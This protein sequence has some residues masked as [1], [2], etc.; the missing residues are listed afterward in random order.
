MELDLNSLSAMH[1]RLGLSTALEYGYRVAIGLGRNGHSPAV[2]LAVSLDGHRQQGHLNWLAAPDGA[3]AQL[4][5]HR[6]T[7]DTAEAVALALVHVSKGWVV[8]RRLQ[9]REFGDWRL[10]DADGNHI[11][12]EV[13]G[14]DKVDTG[15]RRLKEKL[16]Q[17]ER[18]RT[19]GAKVACV[20][21]LAPPRSRLKTAWS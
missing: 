9:R 21:E 13:S 17:V 2:N 5:F 16:K 3:D 1:P 18:C 12:L 15:Q 11:A 6:I 14:V 4:D 20:V 7:E 19:T 8:E 10:T